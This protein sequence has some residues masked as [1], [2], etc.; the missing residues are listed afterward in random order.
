MLGKGTCREEW[1]E[2]EIHTMNLSE[3]LAVNLKEA[4]LLDRDL[5]LLEW[6]QE[7]NFSCVR[8][9]HENDGNKVG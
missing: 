7:Q 1:Q 4:G 6:L 8:Y 3:V 9:N 2:S 5:S